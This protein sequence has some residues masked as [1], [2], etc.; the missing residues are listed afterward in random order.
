MDSQLFDIK[1]NVLGNAE[2][3]PSSN[4][5]ARPEGYNIELI[6]IHNI[7]LPPSSFGNSYVKQFFL[8]HL[9]PSEHPY[10]QHIKDL[11]VSAHLF[12]RRDGSIMQFVPFN[13]RAWH[14]GVSS[15][16]G[17]NKC[18]DFSIGIEME[19]TDDSPYEDAQYHALI[20]T[21]NALINQYPH[22]DKESIVGHSDIAPNRKTDPG[23][24]F[25][26]SYYLS[27]LS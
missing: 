8:G 6:V 23:K 9:N 2:Y 4:C 22:L 5:N 16:K 10:F 1:N 13:K 19:G 15:Y 24:Y 11:K 27:C 26:W 25:N 7:S 14:A 18:N 12:I 21:T 17:S 20:N 3:C